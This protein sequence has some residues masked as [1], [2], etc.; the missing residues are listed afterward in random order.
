MECACPE[1]TGHSPNDI[2]MLAHRLRRWSNNETPRVTAPCLLGGHSKKFLWS[3]CRLPWLH[4]GL[5][6]A[7]VAFLARIVD[8]YISTISTICI[9]PF[10]QYCSATN[11]Q[12]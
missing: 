6:H 8:V 5:F 10:S 12:S 9:E 11:S 1:N 4:G 2:S 3:P 7:C